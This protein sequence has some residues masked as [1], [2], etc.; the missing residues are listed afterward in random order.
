MKSD[1]RFYKYVR[2]FLTVY[3]PKNRC[4]SQNTIKA[5]RDTLNLFR[6]FFWEEKATPFTPHLFRYVQS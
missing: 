6:H 2:G 1:D 5:Y 4:Y 3:L